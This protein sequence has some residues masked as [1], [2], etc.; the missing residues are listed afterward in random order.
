MSQAQNN[1]ARAAVRAAKI[2]VLVVEDDEATY[3]AMDALLTH[4]GFETA[5]ATTTAMAM[6]LLAANPR[7]VFLDL[8]LPD[9]DGARVL[10]HI[11]LKQLPM[12]VA[13][14]TGTND[15]ERIR[16]VERLKPDIVLQKPLDFLL[17]LEKL[18]AGPGQPH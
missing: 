18:N 2:P 12:T 17:L 3:K 9:G 15:P 5:H 7:Y 1:P 14:I 16:R 13:V 8:M 11:R 4:Y 10:E 6:T